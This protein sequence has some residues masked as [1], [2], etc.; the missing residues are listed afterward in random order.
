L[1]TD[2]ARARTRPKTPQASRGSR[3][4]RIQGHQYLMSSRRSRI[5]AT[6]WGPGAETARRIAASGFTGLSGRREEHDRRDRSSRS[7]RARGPAASSCLDGDEIREHLFEGLTFSKEDRDTNI[8][9]IGFVAS[10]TGAQRRGRRDRS[11]LPVPLRARRGGAGLDRQTSWR[12]MWP[13]SIEDCEARGREGALRQ[14]PR[15]GDIP[16]FTGVSDPYEPPLNPRSGS[17]PPAETPP[18][19][20]AEVITWLESHKPSP[21]AKND[22]SELVSFVPAGGAIRVGMAACQVSLG[23]DERATEKAPSAMHWSPPDCPDDG[24]GGLPRPAA[25]AEHG[26][27]LVGSDRHDHPRGRTRRTR[28]RPRKQS[29]RARARVARGRRRKTRVAPRTPSRTAPRP[30]PPSLTSCT[31]PISALAPTRSAHEPHAASPPAWRSTTGGRA[32]VEN[33]ARSRPTFR[34]A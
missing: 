6:P 23:L 10:L 21:D 7:W 17:R 26:G 30:A 33:R 9:R 20:A 12:C 31:P 28:P 32:A 24:G 11:H 27:H 8:R 34:A 3:E 29:R 14:K 22:Q 5:P 15:A 16:E 19:P 13:T 4:V 1:E 25:A 18:N 2:W